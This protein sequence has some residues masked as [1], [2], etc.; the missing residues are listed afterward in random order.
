VLTREKGVILF[1]GCNICKI[2]LTFPTLRFRLQSF[3]F[4]ANSLHLK[5][6]LMPTKTRTI[7]KQVSK[8]VN[9]TTVETDRVKEFI[10][11]DPAIYERMLKL[12]KKRGFHTTQD[13][14]RF[15]VSLLL[16]R[17]GV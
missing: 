12:K 7:T 16:D 8:H 2:N 9:G 17:E 14:A 5:A 13:V 4:K 1:T 6:Q 10:S 3:H 15:A 11:Y